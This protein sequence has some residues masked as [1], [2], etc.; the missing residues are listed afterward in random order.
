MKNKKILFVSLIG[1]VFVMMFFAN[2]SNTSVPDDLPE[3]SQGEIPPFDDL[4]PVNFSIEIGINDVYIGDNNN[5]WS[6]YVEKYD[7]CS[8]NGTEEDPYIIEGIHVTNENRTAYISIETTEHFI[9]RNVT[10]SNYVAH[11]G[12]HAFAGIYIGN[13]QFGLIDNCTIIN[14]TTGISLA[15][16]M[17]FDYITEITHTIKITNCKF[18]GSHYA[19][20]TGKGAAISLH[21]V[22]GGDGVVNIRNINISYNDIYNYASGILSYDA[23]KIYIENNRIETTY[24]Y[25]V[26]C[27]IYFYTVND[28]T[29]INNS[30]YGCELGGHDY[31]EPKTSSD[32]YSINLDNCYNIEIYGNRFYD[33][34]GNLIIESEPE[35]EPEP[36]PNIIGIDLIPLIMI[37]GLATIIPLIIITRRR[38]KYTLK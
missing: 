37:I 17:S 27:G 3:I 8:G 15:N 36:Q 12:H 30:L 29:I 10:V 21:G 22:G 9:I 25:V 20:G 4:I 6:Y 2:I 1:L 28:S 11:A 32:S 7:W 24:G 14:C 13:G 33:L 31:E 38:K 16:G 35:P 18:I 19:E 34:D 26:E 5:N 23:E